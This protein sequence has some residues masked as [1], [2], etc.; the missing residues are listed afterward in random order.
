MEQFIGV[1]D[2]GVGGLTILN[3]L[4]RQYPYNFRYLADHAFCPYGIKSNR[5]VFSRVD[6]LTSNLVSMGAQAVV[7]ACNTASVHAANLA[8]KYPV[9]VCEVVTPTCNLIAESRSINRVALLATNST[10]RNG[11]YSA[12]LA[13]R[14]IE[15]CN[16]PCSSFVPFIERG[17]TETPA[18]RKAVETALHELTYANVDAVILGCTHFPLLKRQIVPYCGGA[19]IIEC[20]CSLPTHVMSPQINPKAEY[21]TTGDVNLANAAA[22]SFNN[23]C[24]RHISL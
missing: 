8:A 13:K 21:F 20:V 12:I 9:P 22:A 23:I 16:F 18:C 1:I 14:G 6:T 3:R 19:Q 2:S 17:E 15:V 24:F 5:E 7:I 4:R 10:I 11:M